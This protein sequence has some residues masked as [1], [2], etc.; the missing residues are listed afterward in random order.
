[1]KAALY[2]VRD[3][4]RKELL[5]IVRDR[6]TLV[7]AL[8]IPIV[9]LILFGY[10]LDFDV[11]HIRTVVVDLS[12]TRES[13][14]YVAGLQA[15]QYLDVVGYRSTPEQAADAL[16]GNEARVA[17]VI[18]PDFGRRFGTTNR[19]T[20]Q[21]LL[22][23][24]DSQVADPAR[25]ALQQ[26]PDVPA[27]PP[28][29]VRI[30][31]LF[32]PQMRTQVYTIPG[33]VCVL[34]QLVT[35]S[36]TSFSLV[37]EREQGTLEQLM[38]SPVGRLGLIMGK[39]LPYSFLAMI[40]LVAIVLLGRLIFDV[41]FAGSFALLVLLAIPFVLAALAMGL[42]ISTLAQN[43]SQAMQM[44]MLT[45]LPAILLSGYIAPRE[46][47]PSPLYVLSEIIPVTHFIQ[48]SRGIIVRGAGV[49]DLLPSVTA[50]CFFAIVLVAAATARFRKTLV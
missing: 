21:V 35:V 26:S 6:T 38:V 10:A 45:T 37:R 19:P 27:A 14:D 44:N 30:Q 8:L 3:I 42:F 7:F 46:T 31:V 24:S 41:P 12:R 47:L 29:D 23:G 34:L 49:A 18:P 4:M 25:S 9:Q 32:N 50:L 17:V 1:M 28:V 13:R 2:G 16:R 22:D 43:Q 48:I 11:R 33:L 20:V 39:I 15:T 40:E 5:H 36:L